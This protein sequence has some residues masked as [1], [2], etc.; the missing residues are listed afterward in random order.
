MNKYQEDFDLTVRLNPLNS[1]ELTC[2]NYGIEQ[3]KIEGNKD[4]ELLLKAV[5]ESYPM[6]KGAY[7]ELDVFMGDVMRRFT[8][9]RK[10]S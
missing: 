3:G 2:L 6:F 8:R 5:K 4:F 7:V 10:Q 1:R 9:D